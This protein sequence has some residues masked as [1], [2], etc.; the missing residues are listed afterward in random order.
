MYS[1]IETIKDLNLPDVYQT[2]YNHLAGNLK[3]EK[4]INYYLLLSP[5]FI[6]HTG[7]Y[8]LLVFIE[9]IISISLLKH[10]SKEDSQCEREIQCMIAA[11]LFHG[12]IG[13]LP[14]SAGFDINMQIGAIKGH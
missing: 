10:N 9:F 5:N 8:S 14:V 3:S 11:N 4:P 6:L 2:L 13:L 1:P 7:L 12:L